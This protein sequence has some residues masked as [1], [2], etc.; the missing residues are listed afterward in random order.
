[1]AC[2]Y[3]ESTV[4]TKVYTVRIVMLGACSGKS[5]IAVRFVSD[6][7]EEKSFKTVGAVYRCK[8]MEIDDDLVCFQVWD[9][10]GNAKYTE[11]SKMYLRGAHVAMLVY[12]VTKPST[13]EELKRWVDI[14]EKDDRVHTT[15]L[16]GNMQDLPSVVD[17]E[18]YKSIL[19]EMSNKYVRLPWHWHNHTG[20]TLLRSR[21]KQDRMCMRCF[22]Q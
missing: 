14:V 2:F 19:E 15:V 22:L 17:D 11:I 16:V 12:D 7:F 13:F 4:P 1:M 10:S 20:C 6:R 5:A 18:V 8:K 3:V 21:R 9:T